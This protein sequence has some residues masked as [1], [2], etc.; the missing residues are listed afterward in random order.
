[1]TVVNP[2]VD[3]DFGEL[4]AAFFNIAAT[5]DWDF[6]GW[7][8]HPACTADLAHYLSENFVTALGTAISVNGYA[9]VRFNEPSLPSQHLIPGA[10][11]AVEVLLGTPIKVF[12]SINTFWRRVDVALD[13]PLNRSRGAGSKSLHLDFVNCTLPPRYVVLFCLRSDPFGGGASIIGSFD[14]LNNE[15]SESTIECLKRSVFSDGTFASLSNVGSEFSPFPIYMPGAR[16]P[17]RF[18]GHLI[19]SSPPETTF[20]LEALDKVLAG[21][22][23]NSSATPHHF[24]QPSHT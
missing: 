19:S 18:T 21:R 15:L 14:G 24:E 6:A 7:E 17:W 1:M 11:M 23:P 12:D 5:I 16:M 10:A 4:D 8:Q 13:R 20:A 9:I 22:F 3:I 2:Y